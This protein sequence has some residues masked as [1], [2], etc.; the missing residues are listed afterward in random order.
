MPNLHAYSRYHVADTLPTYVGISPTVPE[1][2][3]A[4]HD[5]RQGQVDDV[6]SSTFLSQLNMVCNF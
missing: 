6:L 5:E 3:S 1:I 2:P 4:I